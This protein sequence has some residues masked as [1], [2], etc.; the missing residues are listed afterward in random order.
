MYFYFEGAFIAEFCPVITLRAE[1]IRERKVAASHFAPPC[2]N[3]HNL[4]NTVPGWDIEDWRER[5]EPPP[6]RTVHEDGKDQS[7]TRHMSVCSAFHDV[8]VVETQAGET[9]LLGGG[10]S[11]GGVNV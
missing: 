11:G 9:L 2:V 1:I 6:V 7:V 10:G 4:E 5:R 3:N 8:A